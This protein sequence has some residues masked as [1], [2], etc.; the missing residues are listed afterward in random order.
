MRGCF[1]AR[2]GRPLRTYTPI[3]SPNRS[4]PLCRLT[5]L[6]AAPSAASTKPFDL[7]A[8]ATLQTLRD[9]GQYKHLQTIDGPMDAV[10]RLKQP[11]G[12]TRRDA[13]LLLQQL[14]GPGQP[15]GGRRG[16]CEGAQG[17]RRGHGV[18]PVHLRH[19]QPPPR[20]RGPDRKYMG[21][22]ASYTFV[23][24]WTANE[25]IFPTLC[26]PGD[27]IISDELNHA[28]IIDAIRLATVIKKGVH[29]SVYKNNTLTGG[30][31]LAGAAPGGARANP[32]VT[33]QIWVVTD[34]VF[35]MEGSIADLPDDARALR[36]VRRDPRRRRFARPRR[37]GPHRPRHA[38]A[39]GHD[40]SRPRHP[41][42]GNRIDIFSG[43]LGKA[44]GGGAGGF[45]AG[46][47]NAVD[48]SSSAAAPR[49]SPT[50]SPSRSPQRQEGDRDPDAS[51]PQRVQRLK[52]TSRTRGRRSRKR[53][54][55]CSSRPPPSARSSSTTRPRRSR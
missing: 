47:R 14:P 19:V 11:D 22:E 1:A 37:H 55:T 3:P 53:A 44:L 6:S 27:I 32:A 40:R 18:G 45:V 34:G 38:R 9:G 48:C 30:R 16:G 10:V 8:A 26:E 15:P 20:A 13:L 54:S 33:G 39:L 7:R 25:A 24:C 41:T 51:E 23:S 29:K 50:P 35:S 5:A 36:Q 21:T 4:T 43:T 42:R 49:S 52:T 17:L 46:T 31:E 12:S 28:C 2:W